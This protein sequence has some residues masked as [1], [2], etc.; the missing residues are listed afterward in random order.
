M[1]APRVEIA[2][3]AAAAG[4]VVV[5]FGDLDDLGLNV[6]E[7]VEGDVVVDAEF[8]EGLE[9][10]IDVEGSLHD[11]ESVFEG[12]GQGGVE[13]VRDVAK[14]SFTGFH[15]FG[16]D[17]AAVWS[18][19]E[20]VEERMTSIRAISTTLPPSKKYCMKIV[21]STSTERYVRRDY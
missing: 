5:E 16:E 2:G 10:W 11:G 18:A 12:Y 19:A 6:G 3:P 17:G 15:L 20:V 21:P 7:G 1:L 4:L 13:L 9:V 14:R 8:V